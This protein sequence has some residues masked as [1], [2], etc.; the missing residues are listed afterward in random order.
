MGL[1]MLGRLKDLPQAQHSSSQAQMA[2]DKQKGHITRHWSNS[3][4]DSSRRQGMHSEI[5]S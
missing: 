4:S 3:R 2:T 5:Y 1:M